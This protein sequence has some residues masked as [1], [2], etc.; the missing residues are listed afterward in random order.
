MS[1]PLDQLYLYLERVAQEQF[2]D[3]VVIYRF[4]P[5]GSKK[6]EDLRPFTLK[7]FKENALQP[8]IFCN[9]QEP[10]NYQFYQNQPNRHWISPEHSAKIDA[11]LKQH[12]HTFPNFNFRGQ[13]R[14]VWDHAL[15]IHSMPKPN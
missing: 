10:L 1:I 8:E 6:I 4:F 5:Y 2:C 11:I 9:D 15:L 7:T 12:G 14:N 3:D 13:I